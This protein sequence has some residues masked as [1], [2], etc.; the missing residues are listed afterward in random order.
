MWVDAMTT[1]QNQTPTIDSSAALVLARAYPPLIMSMEDV[2]NLLGLSYHTV[3]NELQHHP[4]FPAK[5]D[6]FK[7]PRWARNDVLAWA[8][9][10]LTQ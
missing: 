3:R 1:L 9:V 5:L 10:S 8:G 6:R 4:D 7:H 2:A